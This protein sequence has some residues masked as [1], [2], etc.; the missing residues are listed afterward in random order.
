MR[1][2]QKTR[3]LFSIRRVIALLLAL[4]L[5]M[6]AFAAEDTPAQIY[7]YGEIHGQKAIYQQELDAW[8]ACYARG[9]RHLFVEYAYYTAEYLNLWMRA[10]ND[11]LLSQLYQDWEGTLIH[12]MDTL[13]F[14]RAIKQRYPET[15]FHGTDIGHQYGS[16]GMRYLQLLRDSG[17]E[18]SPAYFRTQ[19]AIDQ[20]RT[21]YTGFNEAYRENTMTENFRQAFD[22]LDSEDVMGIYGS[23]H[24]DADGTDFLTGTV[25]TMAAQLRE[26]Y[27]EA[28]HTQI[29]ALP[30]EMM[31]PM[32]MA[33]KRYSAVSIGE[34]DLSSLNK[35]YC[36]AAF[37]RLESA[38][39]DAKK[40]PLTGNSLPE[41]NFPAS[42]EVGQVFA[43]CYKKKGGQTEWKYFRTDGKLWNEMLLAEEF[44][45]ETE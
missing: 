2:Y 1:T 15:I 22:A 26:T 14:L 12:N 42:I 3:A 27:G 16:T 20:G 30:E 19:E 8:G 36:K 18:N 45:V 31:K 24:V 5:P 38:Y 41:N 34:I 39:A 6:N 13:S 10:D 33:G 7:L 4:L 43:I 9:M 11:E 17:Q 21:Y 28:L 40:R 29:L 44:S 23:A 25:P 35:D 37:Y 32:T